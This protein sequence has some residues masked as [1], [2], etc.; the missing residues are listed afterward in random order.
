MENLILNAIKRT[1]KPGRVRR[2]GYVPAVIYGK[3]IDGGI[4]VK[5]EKGSFNKIIKENWG[6]SKISVQLKDIKKYC[7][8]KNIQKH[9]TTGDILHVDMQAIKMDEDLK[10]RVPF[11]FKGE[12]SLQYDGLLLQI[13]KPD[14][15]VLGKIDSIPS[16][17]EF[18]VEGKKPGDKIT[19]G[20][21]QLNDGAKIVGESDE[22][23]GVVIAT[24][25]TSE[26]NRNESD[27]I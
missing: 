9:P 25:K 15:E 27:N 23:V 21:I 26:P 5:F 22:M 13:I 24:Q 17:I 11:V 8:I 1:E 7:V 16:S 3:D 6:A 10:L 14:V 20:D 12:E 19:L 2:E 18:N 4:A